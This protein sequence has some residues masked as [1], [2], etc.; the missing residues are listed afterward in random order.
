MNIKEYLDYK[1]CPKYFDFKYNQNIERP[2]TG[3]EFR[4]LIIK[5]GIYN[6]LDRLKLTKKIIKLEEGKQL[7]IKAFQEN[8]NAVS[9]W[10]LS[11][12]RLQSDAVRLYTLYWV[13]HNAV[14]QPLEVDFY[15]VKPGLVEGSIDLIELSKS[16]LDDP[17]FAVVVKHRITS[18]HLTELD[19]R[20]PELT[21]LAI[22]ANTL[23]IR[24]DSLVIKSDSYITF[25]HFNLQKTDND[26]KLFLEDLQETKSLVKQ[27]IFPKTALDSLACSKEKCCFWNLCRGR[28]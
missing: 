6:M 27:N 23:F 14:N 13:N 20:S 18:H 15:I 26:F 19:L 16:Q 22:M 7:L 1:R 12:E 4:N 8:K 17:G 9:V 2:L 10:D 11:P 21:A 28:K 3:T 5:Q 25:K 24:V